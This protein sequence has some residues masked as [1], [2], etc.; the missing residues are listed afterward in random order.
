MRVLLDTQSWLWMQVSPERLNEKA[1]AL[2][3]DANVELLLSAASSWEMSIKYALGKLPLP[4]P[5][6]EY[7][8][9]RL[10]TSGVT[11]IPVTHRHA[12]HVAQLPPHHRD[13]F[14]R[15]LIAQAQLDGLTIL[16][17]DRMFDQYDVAVHRA[18]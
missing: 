1:L 4:L 16:T 8:P 13:P 10:R 2:V 17:A 9:D 14:D 3:S 12:L 6:A 11:G 5:P 7:V 15:V 18:D